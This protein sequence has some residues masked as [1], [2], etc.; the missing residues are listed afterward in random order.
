[1]LNIRDDTLEICFASW[2]REAYEMFLQS[3]QLP[4]HRL[5]YDHQADRYLLSAPA[6]FAHLFGLTGALPDRGRLAMAPHLFDYQKFFTRQALEARRWASWW[7]TG[8][9]KTH[10]FLEWAR[11]VNHRTG[12]RVLLIVP[13]NIIG[14]TMDI[15]RQFFPDFPPIEK[16]ETR[17]ALRRWCTAGIGVGITNHEKFI[18][19]NGDSEIISEVRHCAGVVLDEASILKSGGGKIKWSLIKSCRGVEYKLACTAT[20]APNEVMEYASQG[21]WLEKL[22]NEGEI[23]WTYFTRTPAGEWK[24]KRHAEAAFFR[25]MAGWSVYLR[26]PAHYGFADNLKDLPPPV[27]TEHC[28]PI[29]NEQRHHIRRLPDASGQLLAFGNKQVLGMTDRIKYSE[30][31]K[32]F[33]YGRG[34]RKITRI[35]SRKPGFVADLIRQEVGFGRQVLVWTLFDAESDLILEALG[36]ADF[37]AEALTGKMSLADR[38]YTTEA[39][40]KGF[41]RVLIS[42]AALVGFGLNFQNCESMIFSGFSDSWEQFYQAI[43]RAY[44]YG[45]TKPVHVHIPY[46]PEL[47]GV[48]WRNITAKQAR[49]DEETRRQEENY[50]RAMKGLVHVA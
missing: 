50:L 24:V 44:R 22:R 48:V 45:Q 15:R 8:L 40:R 47:E 34:D 13:L 11:Q 14:Q 26:N 5:E 36:R 30:I 18:P 46:I 41:L 10:H 33:I 43:R 32:G 20:P 42:K 12:G 27:M 39:F 25:F 17:S 16:I 35:V 31:A 19:R 3:K 37:S 49:F 4:E 6:R 7:D 38:T 9:G 1:M 2:G 28:L 23:L 29:T 21:S